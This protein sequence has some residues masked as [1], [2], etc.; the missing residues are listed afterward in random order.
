M[1]IGCFSCGTE[2]GFFICNSDPL[3]ERFRREWEGSGGIGIVEMLFRCNILAL[4]G[5][6]P[7]PKYPP[8]KVMIWD[9]YQNKCIAELEFRTDV[10]AVRLRRDRIVVALI[11]KVY[12]YNFA[13]L[14]LLFQFDTCQNP[15]GICA[16]SA[17]T[18]MVLAVP[19]PKV[20]QVKIELYSAKKS[21]LI[22]AHNTAVA[23]LGL[24]RDGALLA[25]ASEKGTL[26]R[27]WNC[28]TGQKLKELRRGADKAIIHSLNFNISS[29]ALCVASDKGTAHI[30]TLPPPDA[31]TQAE[32]AETRNKSSSL[33]FMKDVLPRYFSS[34]WSMAQFAM[35]PY[36][37]CAFGA[38]PGSI[39]VVSADGTFYKF[40]L[41]EASGAC[42]RVV[43][44][45]FLKHDAQ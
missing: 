22:E 43:C 20:G 34:E 31:L 1:V 38:E 11:N 19:G 15:K 23:M 7:N 9:D 39:V 35:P 26:I 14:Q 2:D 32:T 44:E 33:S 41:D 30:F 28:N 6:G 21:T 5:G 10:K 12:V 29:T 3:K 8:N 37:L 4:V 24:A 25:S 45:S 13:D 36:S 27:I 18:E 17:G 40:L 16:L 42:R